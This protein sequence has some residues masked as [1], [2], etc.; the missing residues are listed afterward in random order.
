MNG[1][2]LFF[3]LSVL[4]TLI[5]ILYWLSEQQA[6][7][8]V[9]EPQIKPAYPTEAEIAANPKNV[10][11][12]ALIGNELVSDASLIKMSNA[13]SIDAATEGDEQIW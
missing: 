8:E 12:A 2:K 3:G 11:L 4:A 1:L 7:P 13:L 5:A 10:E 6:I 9:Q